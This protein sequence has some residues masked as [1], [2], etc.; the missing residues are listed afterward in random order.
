MSEKENLKLQVNKILDERSIEIID[1]AKRIAANPE[2]GYKEYKT[3][4]LVQEEF[5]KLQL[6]HKDNLAITGVKSWL[7]TGSPGPTLQ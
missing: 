3:A 5:D 4:K 6:P 1:I 7:D 2:P